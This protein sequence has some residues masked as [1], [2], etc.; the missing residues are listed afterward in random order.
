MKITGLRRVSGSAQALW[1]YVDGEKRARVTS[2][3]VAELGLARGLEADDN[4]MAEVIRRGALLE[5]RRASLSL[6]SRRGRSRAELER[7]LITKG[8]DKP[9]IET[10]LEQL[11]RTGLVNDE[12][13]ARSYAEQLASQ[14]K[15]GRRAIYAK[16]RQRGLSADLASRATSEAM[17]EED[18]ATAARRAA[19][20][21]LKAL[22]GLD[23]WTK[24]RR[25]YGYLARRG[26]ASDVISSVVGDLI[27]SD[28]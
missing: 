28:E 22:S 21:R 7:C 17:D 11:E 1:V 2:K 18:E 13:H 23:L 27:L 25:L 10:V 3:D 19:E 12:E 20:K 9:I 14:G 15:S 8:F 24:R 4:L 16:L 6:L 26:F 5:A